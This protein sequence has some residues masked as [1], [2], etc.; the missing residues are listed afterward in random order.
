MT[1]LL[2]RRR[3][4]LTPLG[5]AGL[6][7]SLLTVEFV[8]GVIKDPLEVPD[9]ADKGSLGVVLFL[10]AAILAVLLGV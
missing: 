2:G 3:M 6:F 9:T 1:G 10:V 8:D 5:G 7:D 4:A